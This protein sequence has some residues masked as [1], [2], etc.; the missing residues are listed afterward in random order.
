MNM[1]TPCVRARAR[2]ARSRSGETVKP[3]VPPRPLDSAGRGLSVGRFSS[4]GSPASA[5]GPVVEEGGPGLGEE[6]PLPQR[7]VGVAGGQR[8]PVGGAARGARGVGGGE[9]GAQGAVRPLVGR[10]VVEDEEED[11]L[12]GSGGRERGAQREVTGQ[13]EGPGGLGGQ[14]LVPHG[15]ER[16]R[17]LLG[18]QDPLV[19]DAFDGREDRAQRGV[20]GHDVVE[21]GFE[22]GPVQLA[23]QAPRG[24]DVVG[25]AGL[26]DLLEQPQALLRR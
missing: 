23:G 16:D 24:G 4:S 8:R 10:D 25:G 20:A 19:R 7:V 1:L 15:R 12:P 3:T 2:R 6:V 13:V 5:R 21:G 18:C 14:L 9:V 22:G 26:L 11:V 17:G